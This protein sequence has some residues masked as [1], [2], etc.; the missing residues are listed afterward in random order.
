MPVR[1][2]RVPKV[3]WCG[4]QNETPEGELLVYSGLWDPHEPEPRDLGPCLQ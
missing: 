2:S 4:A 1:E 3:A